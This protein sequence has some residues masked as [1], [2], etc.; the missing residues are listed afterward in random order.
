MTQ[1]FQQ[2]GAMTV[3]YL[4]TDCHDL[5][6]RDVL[7]P[8]NIFRLLYV[9][10]VARRANAMK[11]KFI[12]GALTALFF[13]FCASPSSAVTYHMDLTL[14][15][16]S[17]VGTITTDGTIGTLNG[18]NIV[19]YDLTLTN[20]AFAAVLHASNGTISSGT[21]LTAT[22]TALLF[23]FSSNTGSFFVFGGNP[24]LGFEDALGS[25]SAHPSTISLN[26]SGVGDPNSPIWT[27]YRGNVEIALITPLP[28][29]LP[30]FA[31][32][33]GALGLLG[34]RRKRKVQSSA[35]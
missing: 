19:D 7:S 1:E 2:D 10:R 30:L 32:G 17:A 35:A 11:S 33:L 34:W 21:S 16:A 8:R 13:S 26:L 18:G 3:R 5:I 15:T 14:G 9:R 28:G 25:L 31:T 20:G 24:G 4:S 22:S 12:A 23:N 29:A 6:D 27:P